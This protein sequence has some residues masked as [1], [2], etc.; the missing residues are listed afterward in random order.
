MQIQG[1]NH[2]CFSVSDLEKS[3]HFYEQVFEAKL[4]VTGRKLAYFDLNGIWIALNE[5]NDIPR[6][7]SPSSYTHI[8]FTVLEAEFEQW[9]EKLKRLKI[10]V[11][12]GRE[13]DDRDKRSIYFA[14]LDGHQFELHT[15]GLHDRMEY[16]RN[17]KTHMKFFE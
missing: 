12:P 17:E 16:Y 10:S 9:E 1:V 3:I 5:E 4:L 8:A 7:V 2:F 13:R 11:L 6:N 15:G 14:D